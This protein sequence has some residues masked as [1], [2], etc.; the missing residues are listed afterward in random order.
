MHG[1]AKTK[2]RNFVMVNLAQANESD[3]HLKNSLYKVI[4]SI[5]RQKKDYEFYGNS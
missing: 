5:K 2:V 3:L 1:D 4:A